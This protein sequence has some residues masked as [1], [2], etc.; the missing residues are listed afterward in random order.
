LLMKETKM[1]DKW[2]P[3]EMAPKNGKMILATDATSPE[4]G[5][6]ADEK[7]LAEIFG[8]KP[9]ATYWV[10]WFSSRHKTGW[11]DENGRQHYPAWWLSN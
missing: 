3:I 8:N 9:P 4:L 2:L 1:K 11:F 6:E 7:K 5:H 10:S